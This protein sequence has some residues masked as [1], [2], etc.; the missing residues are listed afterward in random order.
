M[1]ARHTRRYKRL[2]AIRVK[3]R[4]GHAR[5]AFA[6][7]PLC[8]LWLNACEDADDALPDQ[9][10]GAAMTAGD[11]GESSTTGGTGGNAS[12]SSAGEGGEAGAG[13]SAAERPCASDADCDDSS[14]CKGAEICVEID[15]GTGLGHCSG[16]EV[17]PCWPDACDEALR[18]CDCSSSDRDNDGVHTK[19]CALELNEP[20]DCDDDDD[21][22]SPNKDEVCDPG[23]VDEDCDPTTFRAPKLHED[24]NAD[25]DDDGYVDAQCRNRSVAGQFFAG[26]DCDDQEPGSHPDAE[27][28]CDEKD[29]D[30]DGEVDDIDDAPNEDI[31]LYYPDNDRD[32]W[33]DRDVPP[34][35]SRCDHW[36][37]EEYVDQA[38]DCNDESFDVNP[39]REEL[40][41]GIDDDCNDKI[42]DKPKGAPTFQDT[43]IECDDGAWQVRSCPTDRLDCGD[44]IAEDGC[45]TVATTLCD[46]RD[47]GN[48]CIFSCGETACEEIVS[49][50]I[51][52]RHTCAIA[53][54]M[55]SGQASG[56]GRAFCWGRN[57]S[58]QIGSDPDKIMASPVPI[59][60][61]S[62]H[63]VKAIAAGREHN[64]VI[65]G[66]ESAVFC[67]G[68]NEY[69]KLGTAGKAPR[70]FTPVPLRN[71]PEVEFIDVATGRDHSCAVAEDGR[72]FCWG[73]GGLLGNG[74][75]RDTSSPER[76]R[77]RPSSVELYVDDAERVVTGYDHS[78]LL[79]TSGQVECWG[80]NDDGQLGDGFATVDSVVAQ[81][82]SGL[83][84]VGS[85]CAGAFHTCALAGGQVYC[86]GANDKRQ[87]GIEEAGD[88]RP[89]L[90]PGVSDAVAI[91]CGT[92]FTCAFDASGSVRCWGTNQLGETGREGTDA[93]ATPTEIQFQDQVGTIFGG[94]GY[95]ACALT[96]EG[97]A[98]CW[99]DNSDAQL[100]N[101]TADA[102][103]HPIPLPLAGVG[104]ASACSEP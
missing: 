100:G 54:P 82:V 81:P 71:V 17:P 4:P 102:D 87:L 5:A 38:K 39:A 79:A 72:L 12:T 80:A 97:R 27:E 78:C 50:S 76:V 13:G 18:T 6:V 14:Y 2:V 25:H 16:P 88:G 41:N 64:C 35:R 36:H 103:P 89:S 46:C 92:E 86:W 96:A 73:R 1:A 49:M 84:L 20:E 58:G 52:Y 85:L 98:F 45:E 91:T 101:G 43:R 67:W 10:G 11:A 24:P 65:A 61:E 95:H 90:V 68:D 63:D 47:C 23:D 37:S 59:A 15:E 51:G 42:D 26:D 30:C 3:E 22:R 93:S 55:Q 28:V 77:R 40:C 9:S 94:S 74:N 19:Y 104:D 21:K 66:A 32:G 57:Q 7:L 69:G 99:G 62:L 33:G 53:A 29:N 75:T 70:Y 31:N 34:L 48:R 60:L 83:S 8:L 44:K 56:P